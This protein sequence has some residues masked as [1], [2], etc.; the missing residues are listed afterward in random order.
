MQ[1]KLIQRFGGKQ[2]GFDFTDENELWIQNKTNTSYQG[3]QKEHYIKGVLLSHFFDGKQNHF[4]FVFKQS[5][6]F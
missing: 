2:D 6:K 3:E 4:V 5:S 1:N